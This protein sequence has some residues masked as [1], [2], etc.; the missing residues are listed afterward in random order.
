MTPADDLHRAARDAAA[1]LDA[2]EPPQSLRGVCVAMC[3]IAGLWAA[4][5]FAIAAWMGWV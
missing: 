2:Q 3:L 5:G 4:V 1:W